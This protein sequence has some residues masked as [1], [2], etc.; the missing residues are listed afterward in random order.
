MI[1]RPLPLLL[2]GLAV[3][4]ASGPAAG[5]PVRGGLQV[6]TP[7]GWQPASPASVAAAV[8]WQPMR[9]G[10]ELGELSL[11]A[12]GEARRTRV[13]LLRLNPA[14]HRLGLST[15]LRP[16]LTAGA[17]TV[18]RAGDSALAALN[19]GQFSGIAPWG[20]TVVEGREV[21]PPGSGPLSLAVVE[22]TAGRVR[23]VDPPN[24][25]TVRA[26]G[27]VRTALQSYPALLT[28]RGEIPAPIRSAGLGVDIAH[29][30]ARLALARLGN[31]ALLV[32]LTRF[33]ALGEGGSAIPFGLTLVETATL[34]RDL[35]AREAVALDG[36]ISAQLMVRTPAGGR[37]VWRAW[38]K[39]P[40]GLEVLTRR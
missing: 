36:G 5:P 22:D 19:A 26:A 21:S 40:L 3:L 32:L 17:W 28:G 14:K 33:D 1:A 11:S 15:A 12:P 8:D 2:A 34:L 31:D 30:D 38:R 9:E 27:G 25:A 13:V 18:D 23:F 35:G 39:V 4:W 37:R 24:L 6:R 10:L 20:W 29:R 16:D 7:G